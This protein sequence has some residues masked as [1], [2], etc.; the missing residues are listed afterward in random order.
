[1]SLPRFAIGQ[2]D[3]RPTINIAVQQVAASASL[4]VVRDAPTWA[5][6]CRRRSSRT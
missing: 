5:S 2:A 4:E 6:A 1:L 3:D